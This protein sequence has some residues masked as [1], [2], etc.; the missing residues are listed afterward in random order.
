MSSL[1]KKAWS[2]LSSQSDQV[3]SAICVGEYQ[4]GMVFNA[5]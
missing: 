4:Y 1:A 2:T 5:T 3:H